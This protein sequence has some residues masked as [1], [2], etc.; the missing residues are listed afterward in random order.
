MPPFKKINTIIEF[1][2]V[3]FYKGQLLPFFMPALLTAMLADFCHSSVD[4]LL[5]KLLI[6]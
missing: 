2:P 4:F 5:L 6:S 1:F 3:L